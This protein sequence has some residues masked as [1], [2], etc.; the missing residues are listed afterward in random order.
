MMSQRLIAVLFL[1]LLAGCREDVPQAPALRSSPVYQNES[2]GLRFLVPERW[3]QA[4]NSTLPAGSLERE[5]LLTRY[6]VNTSASAA[7]LEITCMD[8]DKSFDP[9]AYHS[10]PSF[11]IAEWQVVE[12]P[13]SV[14]QSGVKGQQMLLQGTVDN[15]TYGKE[16]TITPRGQRMYHFIGLYSQKDHNARQQIQ[17]AVQSVA[18]K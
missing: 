8:L 11:G 6:K 15:D 2:A 3:K 7:S 12:A 17:R 14:S 16:V 18:W 1:G 5:L 10:G 4:A 13:H 9:V